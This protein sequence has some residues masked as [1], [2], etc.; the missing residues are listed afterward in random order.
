LVLGSVREALNTGLGPDRD[1][2]CGA[3]PKL[4]HSPQ[5]FVTPGE[6]PSHSDRQH[7]QKFG[8]DRACG[9]EDV[10][11][12]R[13]THTDVLITILCHRSRGRSN[14]NIVARFVSI[15]ILFIRDSLH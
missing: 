14:N 7:A 3:K 10:L 2:Q 9:S 6:S 12:D 8:K 5:D 13:Q 11:A 1:S 15:K 4:P